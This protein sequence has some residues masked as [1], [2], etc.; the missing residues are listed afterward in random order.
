MPFA[1]DGIVYLG[2]QLGEAIQKKLGEN[3]I[4]CLNSG[5]KQ[6]GNLVKALNFA[7]GLPLSFVMLY[8]VGD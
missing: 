5:L 8:F 7:V 3:I 6:L 2:K 4:D 1:I